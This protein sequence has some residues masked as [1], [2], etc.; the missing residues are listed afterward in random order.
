MTIQEQF[1]ELFKALDKQKTLVATAIE[2]VLILDDESLVS[3]EGNDVF[4]E[5]YIELEELRVKFEKA[6]LL[7][8]RIP[9]PDEQYERMGEYE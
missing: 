7:F 2:E 6:N 8:D 5:L 9:T 1:D 3:E 4:E